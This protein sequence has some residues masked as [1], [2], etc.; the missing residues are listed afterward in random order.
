MD[1]NSKVKL[2]KSVTAQCCKLRPIYLLLAGN[3][4]VPI[5]MWRDGG[6]MCSSSG[7]AL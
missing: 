1:V 3:D 7:V 4:T 2:K 6:G 5:L